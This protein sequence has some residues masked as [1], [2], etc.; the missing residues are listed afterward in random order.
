MFGEMA[1]SPKMARNVQNIRE[2]SYTRKQ[3]N[4]KKEGSHVKKV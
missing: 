4:L 3:G 1:D 2:T